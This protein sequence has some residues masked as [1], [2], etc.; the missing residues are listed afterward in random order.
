MEEFRGGPYNLGFPEYG[1]GPNDWRVW[2][3]GICP[4][5]SLFETLNFLKLGWLNARIEPLSLLSCRNNVSKCLRFRKDEEIGPSSS[6]PDKSIYFIWWLLDKS[7][8]FPLREL[9]LKLRTDNSW[10]WK[11]ATALTSPVNPMPSNTILLTWPLAHW[12][13]IH[14]AWLPL[15]QGWP[16]QLSIIVGF[17]KMA[18]RI[19]RANV[20][21]GLPVGL[22]W[23]TASV[24]KRNVFKNK[25]RKPHDART[26]WKQCKLLCYDIGLYI[27]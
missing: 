18:K 10:R 21:A 17:L 27:R 14:L 24:F 20:S 13:P 12:I 5:R 15:S 19:K 16:V 23:A 7:I 22:S 11:N 2:V 3:F 25:I 1:P 8:I 4:S 9:S 6:L 26:I